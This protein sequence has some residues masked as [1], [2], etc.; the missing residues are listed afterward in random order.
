MAKVIGNDDDAEM[1]GALAEKIA[2]AYQRDY[3]D[4]KAMN[5]EGG[6]QTANLLP[7]AF[8]I[9]P[10]ELHR[11]VVTNL[12]N[13]V[14]ENDGHPTT[15]FLGTGYIL[16]MLSKNGH[17]NLAYE[18][19]NKT[20]YPSWGYMVEKGATT[21]WELW[22]SDTEPPDEMNSRNH[23][24]LGCVGEW[25]WNTLAGLNICEQ[26]P[27]FKRFIVKPQPV[28]DLKWVKAEYETGYGKI[29]IDWKAEGESF[30]LKLTVPP[31]S[32]AV[33]ELSEYGKNSVVKESGIEVSSG[34]VEGLSQTECGK[35]LAS[36]G[37]YE[38]T[39]N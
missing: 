33:V 22:N 26:Q 30:I 19:I 8:G 23:F 18:M 17:H 28:G 21:I 6:T 37:E 38:F 25:V 16:P 10:D 1:Y 35:I 7:L 31:N 12:V 34:E 5:Y 13:D 36:A 3:W 32:S 2:E 11:Q 14:N 20:D 27:G 9:T 39:V 4:N 24:A 29:A 15:G